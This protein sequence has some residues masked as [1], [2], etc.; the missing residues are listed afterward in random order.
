MLWGSGSEEK[1]LQA[2]EMRVRRDRKERRAIDGMELRSMVC[3]G[4]IFQSDGDFRRC[5]ESIIRIQPYQAIAPCTGFM[6]LRVS[7]GVDIDSEIGP[8]HWSFA[9]IFLSFQFDLF[10]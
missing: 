10:R 6:P 8:C 7:V 5:P 1:H 3:E 4:L 9:T 2:A